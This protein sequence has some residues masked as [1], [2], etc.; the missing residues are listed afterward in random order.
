[1]RNI[2]SLS[3]VNFSRAALLVID[4]QNDF[5]HPDGAN[6]RWIR[7]R[8]EQD[9]DKLGELSA[10]VEHMVRNTRELVKICR[11]NDVPV[12]WI[13]VVLNDE[14]NCRYWNAEGYSLC[15]EGSWG[16]EWYQGFGPHDD[17][18]EIPKIRHSA[19]HRTDLNRH[20]QAAGRETLIIAGTA[21]HGCVEG[22]ARDAMA[23]DYWAIVVGEACGQLDME[24]HERAL[25]R[26]DR[27][28]GYVSDVPTVQ[29]LV[30]AAATSAV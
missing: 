8:W 10:A 7:Q 25:L 9:G 26:I 13:R 11:A 15:R 1:M 22:T 24:A 20:L 16:A 30:C 4:M 3:H 14:T 6:G 19:F 21:T 18:I 2:D 23:Y 28:F 12:I 29:N 17:E 27:L 5:I